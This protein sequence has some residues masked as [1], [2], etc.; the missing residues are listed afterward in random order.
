MKKKIVIACLLCILPAFGRAQQ[1]TASQ[2]LANV[3]KQFEQVN[4]YTVTLH[5]TV[6]IEH[7][8][9]PDMTVKLYFKQPDKIHIESKNFAMLPK[10]GIAL[11][12]ALLL[13]KFDATLAATEQT[14][15]EKIYKLRLISKPEPG[16]L[17]IESYVWVDAARWIITRL[18]SEPMGNRRI[19]I[20]FEDTLIE[21]KYFLPAKITASFGSSAVDTVGVPFPESKFSQRMPRKG[22][23][24][25][26]YSG[27]KINSGL[28]D[29]MFEK[30]AD[31]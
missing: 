16:K 17:T 3:Q 4:D 9:I 11:T 15:K 5:A 7:L 23:V 13:A 19:S 26:F 18:E 27:Y 1:L 24:T 21:G 25:I 28:P 30:K 29:E 31:E 12:P 22:S 8:N 6:N 10:E 20:V 14:G 2:I